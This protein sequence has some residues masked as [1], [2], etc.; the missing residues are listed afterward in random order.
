MQDA[1][2]TAC[3]PLKRHISLK[4]YYMLF[5]EDKRILEKIYKAWGQRS[6]CS[7]FPIEIEWPKW[8]GQQKF[9]WIWTERKQGKLFAHSRE[10][11]YQEDLSITDRGQDFHTEL[12]GL[13]ASLEAHWA[14]LLLG[15][16]KKPRSTPE[17][18][19]GPGNLNQHPEADL[20]YLLSD[21]A[22]GDRWRI[23]DV[24]K[25]GWSECCWTFSVPSWASPLGVPFLYQDR[26]TEPKEWR[27]LLLVLRFRDALSLPRQVV[28]PREWC[29]EDNKVEG[30]LQFPN[31]TLELESQVLPVPRISLKLTE[32]WQVPKH[33]RNPPFAGRFHHRTDKIKWFLKTTHPAGLCPCHW[34]YEMKTTK[35]ERGGEMNSYK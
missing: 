2:W 33:P 23:F 31:A 21:Q 28:R 11:C 32:R 3:D 9:A 26:H 17:T 1:R 19:T 24:G 35:K 18:H 13:L 14:E 16:C 10:C 5:S 25:C 6:R 34:R 15:R 20:Q 8:R 29:L 12:I 4:Y 27:C 22:P 30:L 7:P